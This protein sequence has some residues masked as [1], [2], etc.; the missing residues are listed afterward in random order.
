MWQ[1]QTAR[2]RWNKYSEKPYDEYAQVT[3]EVDDF[4]FRKD[5]L[6]LEEFLF[7]F[8][9]NCFELWGDEVREAL[10]ARTSDLISFV[11]EIQ[12]DKDIK[13]KEAIAKILNKIE[14]VLLTNFVI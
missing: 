13:K 6:D 5:E 9:K 14:D 1:Q 3:K 10:D 2:V 11:V 7:E 12:K 8:A 4:L